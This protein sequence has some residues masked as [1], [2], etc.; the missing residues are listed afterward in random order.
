MMYLS[1]YLIELLFNKFEPI[2]EEGLEKQ[3]NTDKDD[4]VVLDPV[5]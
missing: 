3:I 1:P 2:A 4:G 5:G